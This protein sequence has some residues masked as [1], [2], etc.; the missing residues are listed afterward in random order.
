M[1]WTRVGEEGTWSCSVLSA[2][3]LSGDG[4]GGGD[5]T[6]LYVARME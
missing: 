4:D 6:T 3:C 2:I 5:N 1:K